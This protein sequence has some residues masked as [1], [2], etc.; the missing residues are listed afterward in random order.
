MEVAF[1]AL[2]DVDFCGGCEDVSDVTVRECGIVA[3]DG[4][5]VGFDREAVAN[6]DADLGG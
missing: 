4:L 3:G 1:P 2:L 6:D 5:G